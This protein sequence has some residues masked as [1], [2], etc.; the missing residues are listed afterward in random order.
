MD[1]KVIEKAILR[2]TNV[3]REKYGLRTLQGHPALIKAARGHSRWMAKGGGFSHWGKYHS[4]PMDRCHEAGYPY[5]SVGENIFM[6]PHVQR[7]GKG[8]G[9]GK[10]NRTDREIARMAVRAW[11]KSPD[12][13]ENI[14]HPAFRHLGVGLYVTK[15]GTGY[16][17]QNFGGGHPTGAPLIPPRD[18][19]SK[20]S[21]SRSSKSSKSKPSKPS[22][23]APADPTIWHLIGRGLRRLARRARRK[24]RGV[25][26]RS[27]K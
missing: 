25:P 1:T 5:G 23:K 24:Y 18:N 14:V 16:F 12:H 4:E 15:D 20:P 3:E 6:A 7:S 26:D 19:K 22:K 13:F 9:K 2:Y 11:V 17:T 10:K 8:N 27:K 21:P